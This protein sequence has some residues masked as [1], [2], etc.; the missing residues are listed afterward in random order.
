MKKMKVLIFILLIGGFVLMP[1]D[2]MAANALKDMNFCSK[3]AAVWQFVGY[4]IYALKI[5]V[6]LII[7]ILGIVDFAKATASSDEN[8]IKVA[9]ATLI[10]RVIMGVFIFFVPSLVSIFIGLI[11]EAADVKEK[12]VGCETCLLD[13][14]GNECKNMKGN[15]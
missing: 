3:T 2:V 4:G 13:P 6:P 1:T 5:I 10:Q 8:K 14:T 12:I 9:T 11:S 7:I 15:K